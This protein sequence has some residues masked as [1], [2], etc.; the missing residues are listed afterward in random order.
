[1]SILRTS[2]S[3]YKPHKRNSNYYNKEK[4]LI[5]G[6]TRRKRSKNNLNTVINICREDA[7]ICYSEP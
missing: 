3:S 5:K 7:A 1:M 2:S 6:L 4:L